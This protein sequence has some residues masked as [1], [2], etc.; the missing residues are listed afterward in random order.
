MLCSSISRRQ[1]KQLTYLLSQS[2]DEQ[3]RVDTATSKQGENFRPLQNAM[4]STAA[5]QERQNENT[6]EG[7]QTVSHC[8]QED[9]FVTLYDEDEQ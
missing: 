8:T 4:L 6:N 1:Y 2:K 3:C 7:L 5:V 9:F